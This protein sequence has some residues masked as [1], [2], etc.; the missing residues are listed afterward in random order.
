M[1]RERLQLG[2]RESKDLVEAEVG[3]LFPKPLKGIP[4]MN[5]VSISASSVPPARPL[6]PLRLSSPFTIPSPS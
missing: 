6:R 1:I 3:P 5:A 2:L 4:P